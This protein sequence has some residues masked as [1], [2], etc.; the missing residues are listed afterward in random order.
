MFDVLEICLSTY[1]TGHFVALGIR[2][3]NSTWFFSTWSLSNE[4]ESYLCVY[5]RRTSFDFRNDLT[6]LFKT[7]FERS[8]FVFWLTSICKRKNFISIDSR[9]ILFFFAFEPFM[10]WITKDCFCGLNLMHETCIKVK[11]VEFYQNLFSYRFVLV[12]S[13]YWI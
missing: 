12:Y 2:S 10:S 9:T 8:D 1:L 7:S 6:E 5:S 11:I 4:F 13:L 3:K